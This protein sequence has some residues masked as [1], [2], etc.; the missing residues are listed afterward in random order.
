MTSFATYADLEVRLGVTFSSGDQARA[1]ALLEDASDLIRQACKQK[2]DLVEGDMLTIP[3]TWEDRILLPERPVVQVTDVT[4]AFRD[5][6]PYTLP[7]LSWYVDQDELVRY[8]FPVGL[9]RHFFTTGNGWLGPGYKITIT[10]DHGYATVPTL[11][12]NIALEA[13]TR[14]WVNPAQA[15]SL[16]VAG[17]STTFSAVGLSLLPDEEYQLADAFRRTHRAVSLR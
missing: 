1:T 16:G 15:I 8:A 14:I 13:V 10:Y 3:G 5:G 2:I 6:T 12:K 4:A 17:V 7:A 9:V 11:C